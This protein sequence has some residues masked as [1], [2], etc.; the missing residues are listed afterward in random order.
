M[1]GGGG[2]FGGFFGGDNRYKYNLTLGVDAR[3]LLNRTN[4]AQFNGVLTSSVFGTANRALQAR[5]ID[6]FLRFGF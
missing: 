3:N 1:R 6:V 4:P 2:G 5:R